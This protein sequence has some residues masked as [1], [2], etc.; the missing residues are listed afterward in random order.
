MTASFTDTLGSTSFLAQT[1]LL[2]AMHM[3]KTMHM[4]DFRNVLILISTHLKITL[5]N[6]GHTAYSEAPTQDGY[7]VIFC[8]F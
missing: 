8:I 3:Y 6:Y 1:R 7:P 4:P 2:C 5:L